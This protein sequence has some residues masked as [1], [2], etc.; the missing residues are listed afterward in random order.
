MGYDRLN[1]DDVESKA[2]LYFLRD[3]LNCEQLGFSV[4][5][6][7]DGRDGVEHDHADENEEE[8]YLLVEGEAQLTLEDEP[9]QMEPG[10]A[11][12][13]DPDTTRRLDLIGDSYVV[14]VGAP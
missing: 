7:T 12:R 3:P 10:D 8:V 6:V 2:G 11:V 9:V 1:Y 14:V 5:D 4:I 13:V